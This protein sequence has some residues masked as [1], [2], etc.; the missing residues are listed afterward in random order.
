MINV[1]LGKVLKKNFDS[2]LLLAVMNISGE[3]FNS[4][5]F[6]VEHNLPVNFSPPLDHHNSFSVKNS[7]AHKKY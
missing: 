3:L 6:L 7:P 2:N 1:L 4:A 5:F